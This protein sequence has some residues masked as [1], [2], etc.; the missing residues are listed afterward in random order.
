MRKF[1]YTLRR[2]GFFV[3]LMLAFQSIFAQTTGTIKGNVKDASGNPL[4][5]ASVAL[6]GQRGGTLTDVNGNYSLKVKPGTYTIVVSY[7][8]A[9]AQRVQF[10]V[11]AGETVEQNINVNTSG[12]MSDVVVVGSRSRTPRS[13][14]NTVVPV[15][16]INTKE[17]KNFAQADVTQM[18]TYVAPS[19]QSAR[20][21][22]TDGTDHIDPAGLRGLG[23]DQTLVLLNGKRLHNTAL[24]NINGSVGR[25][26]VGTDMNTI[27]VAAIERIEVLRDGAAAQYG[28]DAIAG[29]INV[30]LKKSYKG[31]NISGMMGQNFTNMPY[32]GGQSI[33]DGLNRQLDFSGG[34]G[35]KNGAYVN[36]SGQWLKRDATNRS[37][38]DNI[39]LVYYGN[40][41]GL[42]AASAVPSGVTPNEYYR[43]L[44]DQ[45]RAT[46]ASRKYDRRNIVAG[47]SANENLGVF[48]NAGTPLAKGV[49]FYVTGGYSNRT[50]QASGFSRNPNSWSQ[51]P[52]LANGQRFYYDGFLPQIHTTLRDHTFLTG[53]SIDLG[54]W[55]LDISNTHGANNLAYEVKNS[56]NAS[57]PASNNIQTEFNAG[58]L[59]F[60]QNTFNFDLD[61]TVELGASRS[62]N[63]AL[64]AEYR[65]E[66]FLIGAGEPNSYINGGRQFQPDP[67]PPY[68]GTN[69]FFTFAPGTAVSGSQVFPGFQ[70]ADAVTAKR[71]VYAAYADVEYK[72]RKLTIGGALRYE[73]YDEFEANYDNVSGK[74][75]A[76]YEVSNQ[77]AVRGSVSTGFRAPSLHQR[78]FQ[79]TST[80]FVAGLPSQALTANNYNPIVKN[81]FG[82]DDLTPELSKSATFGL[83][84]NINRNITFTLDAYYIRIDNRIVLSSQFNRS[85]P[86][87]N[88]ILNS[89]AVDPSINAL[90]FWTNAVNTETKGIDVVIT[91]RFR[92]GAGN[93]TLS[94]AANFNRN[95]VVGPIQSNSVIDDAA[96]NPSVGDASKNPANDLR[97]ALFDRQQR[98][99][100]EVGQPQSK[101]NVTFNYDLRRW[102]FLARAVRFGEITNLNNVDPASRNSAT[103]AFWNDA[104]LETDQTFA[105]RWTTD[106]VFTYKAC[107][108]LNVSLGANNLFDIYPERIFVDNRNDPNSYYNAPVSNALGANKTT[109]GFNAGRDLS[110]RG[111]FLFPANQFGFNGRFLYARISV[112]IFELGKCA[113]PA[114]KPVPLP[115][116]AP[117]PPPKKDTDGDGLTDDVDGCPTVAGPKVLNGC[118]DR[119]GDGIADK[120]D[121]CPDVAG[122]KVFNGCPDKDGDGIQDSKDKC[123]DVAGV[124]KYEGCPIPDRDNDGVA[125]D[126]DR[127]PDV[128]G[129]VANFGCPRLE[130][131]DFNAKNVTFVTGS[132]KLTKQAT[133]ELDELVVILNKHTSL[134]LNIDGHTDNTGSAKVNM[135]LSQKRAD[136]VKA[137]LTGKGIEDNRLMATGYGQEKPVASNTTAGGRAENRRVEF[138][139]RH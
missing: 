47:N 111:R 106:L 50:G 61:R 127:C 30:V 60:L 49:D 77:L 133:N 135:T 45:D 5:G 64:G 6:E 16:V 118:P 128:P 112:D 18:L 62:I 97:N 80:Q 125:D 121:A 24:V 51:Q 10:T 8:G 15:D 131:M 67:I 28:S 53:L 130:E 104:A 32:A 59:N 58:R 79:N 74:I 41:G 36:V 86:L 108:G 102:N 57:L 134:N 46:A 120:D 113:K 83:V 76:R 39:P 78:Y 105:A 27:P 116:P 21:T 122:A 91:D 11:K 136:A 99:R 94:V 3:L 89:N 43:W 34:W 119:D 9:T 123:V 124:A 42:P 7:V 93:A 85:N 66:R 126:E 88:S 19:F 71:N 107:P 70:P 35:W 138:S 23:P 69:S 137:Y 26:S 96:N 29:V 82:I 103:G 139:V 63:L 38:L 22:V 84:G 56:A 31:L 13:K 114:P 33:R 14:L 81:A 52:V 55:D 132:A 40:G 87:V 115:A 48:V 12:E 92:L 117:P 25:G 2:A 98:S 101:I 17:V 54:K 109:G 4:S 95:T 90:Q 65:Y 73:T 68:P 75:A 100:I 37:G 1:I 72:G 20:Q 110:N 129:T 44:M